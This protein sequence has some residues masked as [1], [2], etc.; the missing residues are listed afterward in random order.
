MAGAAVCHRAGL[1]DGAVTRP[2]L[3]NNVGV[4]ARKGTPLPLGARAQSLRLTSNLSRAP[5]EEAPTVP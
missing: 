5:I 3:A 1:P 2:C 4:G